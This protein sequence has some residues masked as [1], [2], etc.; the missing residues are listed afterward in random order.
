MRKRHFLDPLGPRLPALERNILKLRAMQ[1]VRVIFYAEELKRKILDLIRT[2]DSFHI[3]FQP[4]GSERERVPKGTKYPV[5]KALNALVADK[6]ITPEEKTE[7]DSLIKCRNELAHRI[8]DLV[9]DLSSNRFVRELLEFSQG[10]I[11][12]FDYNAVERLLH[13]HRRLD[14]LEGT[15]HYISTIS[16]NEFM[17]K[18]A[19]RTFLREI[20]NSKWKI[21][22]LQKILRHEIRA[23]NEELSLVRTELGG[24]DGF[25]PHPLH[26]Y[27]DGRLTLR[28]AEF[29]YRLY[30]S[31]RSPLA[32]AHLMQISLRAPRHRRKLWVAAG[33][34]KR[35]KV[36]YENLPCRK[37]R[38]QYD[39]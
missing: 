20:Q 39:D 28:G 29:C 2:T 26:K 22:R 38:G 35:P 8:Q 30:D 15:H 24:D 25:P 17:F 27:D 23:L 33:G 4:N 5:N 36:N 9:A 32:V 11:K 1:M 12:E 16:M 3:E 10:R 14:G 18:A 34:L 7:I 6:A 31:G 13:F 19:E 21:H 37:F